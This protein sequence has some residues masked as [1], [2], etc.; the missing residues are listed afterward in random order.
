MDVD[1]DCERLSDSRCSSTKS[2]RNSTLLHGFCRTP[3]GLGRF[4]GCRSDPVNSGLFLRTS[5]ISGQRWL[6]LRST[7]SII[8]AVEARA[9]T[10]STPIAALQ[11]QRCLEHRPDVRGKRR[12]EFHS[13]LRVDGDNSLFRLRLW[14]GSRCEKSRLVSPSSA[15]HSRPRPPRQKRSGGTKCRPNVSLESPLLHTVRV[16]G[17]NMRVGLFCGFFDRPFYRAFEPSDPLE[18]GVPREL[19]NQ[20]RRVEDADDTYSRQIPC[21]EPPLSLHRGSVWHRL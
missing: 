14:R 7:T 5:T 2:G 3:R 8:L 20:L 11:P 9:T 13:E 10:S 21:Q 16:L 6:M 15:S 4:R 19:R 17:V 1:K 12:S 18:G